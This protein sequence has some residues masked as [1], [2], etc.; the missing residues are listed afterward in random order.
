[1]RAAI[2]TTRTRP[3]AS[4]FIRAFLSRKTI[5]PTLAYLGTVMKDFFF[6]QFSVKFGLKEIPIINVDH[7]LDRTV[8]FTPGLVTVYLDFVAFWI[9]P[10]D[11]IG[12][13]FGR[14]KQ[15]EYT[16][17]FLRIVRRC[18]QDAARV[19]RF[20]MTTTQRPAY[21]KGHFRIIH[22]FDPHYLCVPSL[23]VIIVVLAYTFYRK[24]FAELGM[25]QDEAAILNRELFDGAVA[26]T[27]TVLYI[28][29]HS[30]NCIPAALY[31]MTRITPEEVTPSEVVRF[32]GTLFESSATVEKKDVL[33]IREHI[34][35]MYESLFLQGCH[36]DNWITPLQRWLNAYAA[37]GF[38][39]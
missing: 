22:M 6:L 35:D 9:R 23:H 31:A 28:K 24:A 19:Y 30:V 16:A 21:Y 13:R 32:I 37:A 20:R 12:S 14:K 36:D 3:V 27:E 1:M 2:P 15:A 11:Y 25:P 4:V 38:L 34:L 5:G 17:A 33:A 10:L 7:P 18:Y 39:N 29:Q 8:P 26:I